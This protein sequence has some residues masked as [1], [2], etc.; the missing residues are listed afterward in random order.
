MVEVTHIFVKAKDICKRSCLLFVFVENLHGFEKE[1][2]II[3]KK[4][5]NS[6]SIGCFNTIFALSW[7]YV[8]NM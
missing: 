1:G 7:K 5:S 8:K 2:E 6:I 3:I 4:Y